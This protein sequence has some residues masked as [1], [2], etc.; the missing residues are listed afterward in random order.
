M[1]SKEMEVITINVDLLNLITPH[2]IEIKNNKVQL[3]DTTH[4]LQY[5]SG[6]PSTVNVR[7]ANEFERY[8][9]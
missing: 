2:R 1:K 8:E 3:G 7:M 5:I 6:Y 4:K 9:K